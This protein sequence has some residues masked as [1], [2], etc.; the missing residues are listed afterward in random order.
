MSEAFG[1]CL[2]ICLMAFLQAWSI[3]PPL[4]NDLSPS[5]I[6][7]IGVFVLIEF[8]MTGYLATTLIARFVLQGKRQQLYPYISALLYLLHSSI[9]FIALGN[10]LL[11]KGNLAIQLGGSLVAFVCTWSGNWLLTR[12]QWV[13]GHAER[14]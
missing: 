6:A 9:F 10:T 7:G 8:A 3:Q 13:G 1:T 5:M 14:K 12:W 4:Q 2:V 11:E